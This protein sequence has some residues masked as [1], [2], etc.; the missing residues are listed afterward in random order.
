LNLGPHPYQVSPAKRRAIQPFRSSLI[1]EWHR[2]GVNLSVW[3]Q[4][5]GW[6]VV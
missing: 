2:D 4:P 3:F 1:R 5:S 6:P